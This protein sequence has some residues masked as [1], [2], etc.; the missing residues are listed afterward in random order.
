MIPPLHIP[1][2]FIHFQ[3]PFSIPNLI[4]PQT[5]P[6]TPFIPHFIYTIPL[7]F[8]LTLNPHHF[9][10]HPIYYTFHYISL[11]H[12]FPNFPHQKFAYFIPKTF[13]PMFIIP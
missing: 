2:S 12:P 9:L 11:H 6:Q 3:I 13:N 1:R 7:F 4:H 10:L 5:P 8:I